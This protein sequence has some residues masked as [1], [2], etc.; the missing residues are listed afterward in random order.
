MRIGTINGARAIGLG[1][2]LGSIEPG[3]LADLFV[4]SGD[5]ISDI[6]N[7][8]NVRLVMKSGVLHDSTELLKNVEGKL[9]PK[10]EREVGEW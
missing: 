8:R 3:K 4:C 5:P 2:R 1:D 6:H 7:T 10:N 9:G